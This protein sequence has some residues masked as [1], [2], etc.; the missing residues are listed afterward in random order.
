[1]KKWA[2]LT[3]EMQFCEITFDGDWYRIKVSDDMGDV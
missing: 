3:D 1:M 2:T